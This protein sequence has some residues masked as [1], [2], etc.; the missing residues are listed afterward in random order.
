[1]RKQKEDKVQSNDELV[2]CFFPRKVQINLQPK[3]TKA[4]FPTHV[5]PE[6]QWQLGSL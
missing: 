1:M 3:V 4:S 5:V 6:L 2:P